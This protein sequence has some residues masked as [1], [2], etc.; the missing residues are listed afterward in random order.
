MS[1][2]LIIVRGKPMILKKTANIFLVSY[3]LVA[4]IFSGLVL[5]SLIY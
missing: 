4:Y 5:F 2:L 1:G 3:I